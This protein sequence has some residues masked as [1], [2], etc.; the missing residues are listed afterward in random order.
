[1]DHHTSECKHKQ[2]PFFSNGFQEEVFLKHP[3]DQ[4]ERIKERKAQDRKMDHR[5]GVIAEC[6]IGQEETEDHRAVFVITRSIPE[7]V[8]VNGSSRYEVL[9][10]SIINIE[11]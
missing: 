10:G 11:I 1:M 3:V 6:G 4:E 9:C 2:E 8:Q 7:G 5:G